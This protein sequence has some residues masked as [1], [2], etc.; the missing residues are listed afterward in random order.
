MKKKI[1]LKDFPVLLQNIRIEIKKFIFIYLF[2]KIISQ[3][4]Y[5]YI[6]FAD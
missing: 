3:S 6:Y 2:P 4:R 5:K 1:V